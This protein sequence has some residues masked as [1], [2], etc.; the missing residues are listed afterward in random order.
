MNTPDIRWQQRLNHYRNALAQL[1][2]AVALYRERPLSKLE[3]Q[4]LIKA[5]EFTHELAWNLIKDYFAWQGNTGI[6]GSRDAFREAF[7]KGLVEDGERWMETIK[8]RN[9]SAHTY[10][11]ETANA[12]VAAVAD[13]YLALFLKLESRMLELACAE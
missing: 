2:E 3:L 6:M 8:S 11:E 4:G 7:N 10:N 9:Q 1:G 5:F 13:V 12:I